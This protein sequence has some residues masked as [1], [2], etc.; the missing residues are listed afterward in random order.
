MLFSIDMGGRRFPRRWFCKD[1]G[2]SERADVE[3]L[4]KKGQ[5]VQ[6]SYYERIKMYTHLYTNTHTHTQSQ[7]YRVN[8]NK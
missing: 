5:G 6:Y 7:T 1:A 4:H 8:I 2:R 3:G